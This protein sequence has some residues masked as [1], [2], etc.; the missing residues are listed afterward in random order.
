MPAAKVSISLK[1]DL[2]MLV[3]ELKGDIPR[4]RFIVRRLEDALKREGS[5]L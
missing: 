4:S 2:L 3:D 1:P 5:K